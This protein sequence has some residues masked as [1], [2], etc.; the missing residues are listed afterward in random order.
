VERDLVRRVSP[1][2]LAAS[3]GSPAGRPPETEGAAGPTA[4]AYCLPSR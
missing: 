1:H 3:R 4:A 2:R